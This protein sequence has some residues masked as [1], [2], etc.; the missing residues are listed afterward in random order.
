MVLPGTMARILYPELSNPDMVYPTL[1]FD[2]LP[3]G[4]MGI[5]L[6]GFI[7]ALMSQIDSTL[8][9]ASTLI[10]MDFVSKFKPNLDS[11]QLMK[12]GRIFTAIFMVLA[13]LWAPQ[14]ENFESLFKY[15]QKILSYAIPP[16]VAL[17]LIGIFWK[18]ATANGAFITLI[19]GLLIGTAGFLAIEVFHFFE[20][21]FLYVAVLLFVIAVPILIVS[22]LLTKP[23]ADKDV[24]Q[25]LWTADFFK[26]ETLELKKQPWYVNYRYYSIALLIL[27]AVLVVS[28]W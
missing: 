2:L 26:A 1:I 19:T 13:A 18:R 5:V 27:T 9:S 10:A 24:E 3:V 17:F 6:A 23:A 22:S 28:F 4:L 11:K 25:L 7:A 8:N 15:L 16:V 21:H 12:A 20:L 14:I